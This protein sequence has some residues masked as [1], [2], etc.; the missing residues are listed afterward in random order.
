MGAASDI[1]ERSVE[2]AHI[3]AA[4]A[5]AMKAVMKIACQVLI[6]VFLIKTKLLSHQDKVSWA[7]IS[8]GLWALFG[9]NFFRE[10]PKF[11]N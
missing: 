9:I 2:I 6:Y 5:P 1:E 8:I 11:I 4:V 7:V 3:K 10:Y